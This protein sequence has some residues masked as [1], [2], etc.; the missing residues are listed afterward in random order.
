MESDRFFMD[1]GAYTNGESADDGTGQNLNERQVR[2]R[3]M[4]MVDDDN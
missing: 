3:L 2:E 4:T 1:D